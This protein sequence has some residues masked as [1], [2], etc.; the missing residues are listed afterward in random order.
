VG[1]NGIQGTITAGSAPGA[2]L[3]NAGQLF[4]Y[5]VML[6]TE[7]DRLAMPV[8]VGK[9]SYYGTRP[10]AGTPC[11]CH[12]RVT[13][14]G[15]R[16][17]SCDM[18]LVSDGRVWATIDR[19][20]DW[21]FETDA[22]FWPIMRY[23]EKHLY[24]DILEDGLCV[25]RLAKRSAGS[26]DYLL[27]R[28]LNAEEREQYENIGQR[29]AHNWLNGRVA[30]KDAA[31]H[32]CLNNGYGERFPA[33]ITVSNDEQGR[34]HISGPWDHPLGVSIS[35]KDDVAVAIVTPGKTPG[36]DVEKIEPRSEGFQALAYQ[37]EEL[38][39]LPT[40]DRDAWITRLWC[41]KEAVGKSRGT[42]LQ[43]NP[44]KLKAEVVDGDKICVDGVWTETRILGEYA[45]AWTKP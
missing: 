31:R 43:F 5:W 12:V 21:R 25:V 44:R 23:P 32:Y 11:E 16:D 26:T 13:K 19:W 42:G 34:P 6:N 7:V 20:D 35:H 22:R 4:G 10:A 38:A 2:L 40:E 8:K 3:D 29:K 15:K 28:F 14:M 41:A 9:I 39:L 24:G 17:V 1:S 30:A 33:E 27:R 37:N 36:V 45:V 18:T